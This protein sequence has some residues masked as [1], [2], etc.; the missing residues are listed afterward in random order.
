MAIA[1]LQALLGMVSL[2]EGGTEK[3]HELVTHVFLERALE[4]EDLFGHDSKV[5]T[6][7]IYHFAGCSTPNRW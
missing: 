3:S 5:I 7:N 1:A 4:D 2:F 6:E